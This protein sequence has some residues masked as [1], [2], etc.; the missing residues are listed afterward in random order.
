M[1]NRSG[2]K[3]VKRVREKHIKSTIYGFVYDD[4]KINMEKINEQHNR[5]TKEESFRDRR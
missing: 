4:R 2:L 5:S 3:I 1:K